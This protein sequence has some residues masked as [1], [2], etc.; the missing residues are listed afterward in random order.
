M[1][2]A[3]GAG[4]SNESLEA[5]AQANDARLIRNVRWRLLAWSGGTTLVV[6]LALGLALYGTVARTLEANG[7]A[8]LEAR[9]DEIRQGDPR[10]PG[11]PAI[12]YSFGGRASGTFAMLIDEDSRQL[13]NRR[14]LPPD[15]LPDFASLAAPR[16]HGRH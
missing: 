6:L 7:V 10:G 8:L 5:R 3:P 1:A 16:A 12:G 15:G 13:L 2:D 9:L 4:G 14:V 11:G